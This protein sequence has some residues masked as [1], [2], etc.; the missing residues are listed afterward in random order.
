LSRVGPVTDE[1]V[2]EAAA[3][4]RAGGL[5][6]FPTETVYGLGADATNDR[7]VARIFEAKQRPEF[8]P[9]IVHVPNLEAARA[10]AIFGVRSQ[11]LADRFWPGALTL[12]LARR[13]GSDLSLF[14][15]A[16]LDTV[17]L[18]C[19][20]HEIAR[21]LLAA[22]GR[23]VAAPSANRSGRISPTTASHVAD[24][25]GDAVDL[26]LDGG[27]CPI[28][29][30][31]TIVDVTGDTP[32]L[33]RPGGVTRE[34]IESEIGSLGTPD[35]ASVRAPG[36]LASHYAPRAPLR[37]NAQDAAPG[38]VLLAFGPDA[39]AGAVNLSASGDLVEAAANLFAMLRDLDDAEPGAI[40]VMPVP[41]HGL[42]V[43][44]NDRLAR[45]AAPRA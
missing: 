40:A 28:G 21:R 10:H 35:D 14:V 34:A 32:L 33:L 4:L 43:A 9:L 1:S 30:E 13:E 24:D 12:V 45:A 44:I 23:P 37:L 6:A 15:S 16:G 3:I 38:E 8:N 29:V 39:P 5:V 22:A 19:P 31:S 36:M 18:R 11:R 20:A 27:P 25:L 42:G 2:N 41:E 17:A 26:I 7:A